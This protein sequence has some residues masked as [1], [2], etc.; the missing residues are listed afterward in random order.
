MPPLPTDNLRSP[1]ALARFVL[2]TVIGLAL[3]LA[4]KVWAFNELLV[5]LVRRPDGTYGVESDVYEFI[6]GWL[7]FQVTVN[8]GAVFGLGQGQ[9]WLFLIVS[10]AAIGFLT[11]LFATS[12]RQR[13]YQVLLGML[14]AGVLGNMYDRL[15]YGY[16]RDM[17]HALSRF[18]VFPWIF[19]VADSLLCVG[20]TM[21]ILYSLIGGPRGGDA[22]RGQGRREDDD[23]PDAERSHAPPAEV[24]PPR[25]V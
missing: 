14:L 6:P 10:F 5:S 15:T 24:V 25:Q 13:L 21:V 19:N 22:S 7:H 2:T 17:I 3:D 9:R 20:V 4:T 18:D 16:V 12:G 8:Q 23:E 11:Y 1:A